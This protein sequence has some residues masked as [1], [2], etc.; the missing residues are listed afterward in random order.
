[1][2]VTARF[3]TLL[4]R[5]APKL[6]GVDLPQTDPL[7]SRAVEYIDANCHRPIRVAELASLCKLS[8]SHFYSRFHE[9]V[10]CSPIEY[11]LRAAVRRAERLLISDPSM[12]IEE[13]SLQTG[14][15]STSYFRRVFR[16]ITGMSPSEY[17]EK[18]WGC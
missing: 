11:K 6:D 9:E 2:M 16:K 5:V 1:M 4:A 14:F 12:L 10:G 3:Y 15:E 18:E 17:R 13:I 8:E 7:I